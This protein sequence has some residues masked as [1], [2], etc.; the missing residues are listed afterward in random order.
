M[1]PFEHKGYTLHTR[2]VT[3]NGGRKQTIYFFAKTGNKPKSGKPCDKPEEYKV[4]V[5]KR[6]GLPYLKKA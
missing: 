6:T 2:Q 4:G 5:N 3:L 1:V